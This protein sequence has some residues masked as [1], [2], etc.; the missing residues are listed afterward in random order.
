[1]EQMKL[2]GSVHDTNLDGNGSTPAVVVTYVVICVEVGAESEK[3]AHDV[4]FSEF[5]CAM[6]RRF[7][8]FLEI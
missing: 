2:R 5:T 1:M 6:K 8:S 4:T 7:S 3:R